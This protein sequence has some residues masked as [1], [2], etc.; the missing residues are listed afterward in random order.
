VV[1]IH[2][3]LPISSTS[4]S[5]VLKNQIHNKNASSVQ[6]INASHE[7]EEGRRHQL[8][9]TNECIRDFSARFC[10]EE[11]CDMGGLINS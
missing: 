1:G 10:N 9:A 2:A 5:S 4:S 6:L 11:H 3:N 7:K 8:N